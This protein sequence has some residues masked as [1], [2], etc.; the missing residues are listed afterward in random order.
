VAQTGDL[1]CGDVTYRRFRVLS[2]DPHRFD[3]EGDGL[4]CES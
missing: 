3:A 2:P 1:D 4:G